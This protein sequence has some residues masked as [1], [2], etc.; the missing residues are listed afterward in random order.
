MIENNNEVFD[1]L[2]EYLPRIKN[3]SAEIVILI[4]ENKEN[5]ACE[6]IIRICE[7][8]EILL[9]AVSYLKLDVDIESFN[10]IFNEVVE[11]LE[12][13]DYGLVGDLFEYELEPLF[14]QIDCIIRG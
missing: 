14:E 5:L 12:N 7:M 11:A 1:T 6:K 4:R 9:E 3:E 13:E 10:G 2:K 8:L